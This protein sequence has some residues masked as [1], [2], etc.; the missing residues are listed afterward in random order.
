MKSI[1]KNDLQ[2]YQLIQEDMQRQSEKLQLI[3]SENFTSPAV[4]AAVGSIVMHKYS[5]GQVGKRYYEGN[6]VIDKIESLC[7]KRALDTFHL[8]E[9]TWHVNVQPHAGSIANLAVYNALL[10][11]GDKIMGMYLFDGGHLSH[12]WKFKERPIS[13][14]AKIYKTAYYHVDTETGT[15]DYDVIRRKAAK[16]KP[17]MI[18]SG[19][20]AYPR[21][22]D[23]KQLGE[24]AQS[25][26]ALYMAD[27][28]HEAGLIAARENL[29]PFEYADVVTLTT[30]KTLRGP[31]GAIIF[32]RNTYADDVDRSVFPG[33]QGGPMNHSIAGIA[34]ALKEATQQPFLK[35]AAQTI[36][37][38]RVLGRA[39]LDMNYKLV[40]GGTDKHLLLIDLRTNKI[41]GRYASWALDYAGITL[42][43]NTIPGE[44][45]SPFDPSGLRLGTPTVTTRGMG[46][47]EMKQIAQFI[48]TVI[49]AVNPYTN[50]DFESFQKQVHRLDEIRS[51]RQDVKKLCQKFPL[52]L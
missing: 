3:P 30:H 40:S 44:P 8:D 47:S 26:G 11:P 6:Q 38:A 10:H 7:K 17:A 9:K 14:S 15:F 25:V 5:E 2:V 23:H 42:N 34:V 27:I 43:R 33:L 45:G 29:S 36:R 4:R 37:N 28:A 22:I 48:D 1:K 46:E 39:L 16:E 20:T 19:G 51:V 32:C 13:F 18:I 24:I 12:G 49:T 35:Y 52:P 41:S 50:L 21:E 31:K